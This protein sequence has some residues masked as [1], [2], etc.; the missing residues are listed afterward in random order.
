MTFTGKTGDPQKC[1]VVVKIGPDGSFQ[2]YKSVC[3]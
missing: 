1:A 2:F 3:P